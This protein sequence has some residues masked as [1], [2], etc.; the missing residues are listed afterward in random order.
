MKSSRLVCSCI[1]ILLLTVCCAKAQQ[2]VKVSDYRELDDKQLGQLRFISNL[3]DQRFNDWSHMDSVEPGQGHFDAYRYQLAM[4]SYASN[5]ANYYYTPAYPELQRHVSERLIAKMLRFDVWGYWEL[6]SRGFKTFDPD[7]VELTAGSIDPVAH[8]NIMYS[9]H[10]MQMVATYAMLYNSDKYERPGAITFVYDPRGWGLGRKEF[11]YDAGKL[12]KVIRDQF[13]DD[14]YA[15]VQCEPNAIFAECNQHPILGFKLYDLRNGTHYF[16]EVSVPFKKVIDE[17]KYLDRSTGSFM[18]FKYARQNK[19]LRGEMA[20]NDG[21]AAMF[22]HAWSPQDV[23]AIYPVLKKKYVVRQADGT[24]VIPFKEPNENFSWDNGFFAALAAELGDRQT[25]QGIL[26]YADKHWAP[27]WVDGGLH[28][29][30]NDDFALGGSAP[31]KQPP[32]QFVCPRV[33]P[34]TG[35]AL[36][37]LARINV[38]D[39]LLRIFSNPWTAEHFKQPFLADVQYPQVYVSRAVYDEQK[40]ALVATLKPGPGNSPLK[41]TSF[42]IGNLLPGD[43]FNVWV[44]GNLIGN[45]IAGAVTSNNPIASLTW[46]DGKLRIDADIERPINVIVQRE[47]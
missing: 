5:L 20:W 12:A 22:L 17:Q 35:N 19:V 9:G 7:L 28:Y 2:T 3:A 44:N 46:V 26:D 24:A 1:G 10:L 4:M 34:L 41:R 31:E 6:T 23:E 25:V 16:D 47:P 45:L 42:V 37:A 43:S 32:D 11:V 33:N 38:K 29:P 14:G 39:G 40:R 18:A 13:A 27:T 30:R 15:G 36:L 21:W 8:K